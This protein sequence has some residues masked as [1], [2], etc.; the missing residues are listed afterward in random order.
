MAWI[1]IT[2]I[3][4]ILTITIR[5]SICY[6]SIDRIL[7]RLDVLEDKSNKV[8][9]GLQKEIVQIKEDFRVLTEELTE[10]LRRESI[11]RRE[12]IKAI[13]E[14]LQGKDNDTEGSTKQRPTNNLDKRQETIICTAE[15]SEHV[16]KAFQQ[17]K[18]MNFKVRNEL[19]SFKNTHK[20]ILSKLKDNVENSISNTVLKMMSIE[21][22][23]IK[24]LT[25]SMNQA[26]LRL[27]RKVEHVEIM[28]NDAINAL[29]VTVEN[30]KEQ[31]HKSQVIRETNMLK[32][33]EN[34]TSEIHELK[35]NVRSRLPL[36]CKEV[37]VNGV[38][39]II[40]NAN[41]I[42]VYC[43]I[44]T[45]GGGWVVFQRRKDGSEDFNRPW[46]EYKQGFGQLEGEFWL[47]NELLYQ[48]TRYKPR[49]LRIDMEDYNGKKAYA[50]YSSFRI[51]SEELNYKLEVGGYNGN[52]G[53]S[54][55]GLVDK[56]NG[57]HNGQ[58]FSTRDNDNKS[59]CATLYGGGWWFNSCFQANLNGGYKNIRWFSLSRD[60]LKFVEMKFR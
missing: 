53:D 4:C 8:D 10:A 44:E 25:D 11:Y 48:F 52:A 38:Y 41:P 20:D 50:K 21:S 32:L 3:L 51:Y 47:G 54:L 14:L 7:N 18:L 55:N 13:F 45:D 37:I 60:L 43:D 35:I 39:S 9:N 56:G 36:Q 30:Y 22:N 19:E 28:T 1:H 17:E 59:K 23:F 29:N 42:P 49:E 27:L 46:L 57:V 33:I 16:K 40:V 34:M 58:S 15:N 12:D 2:T 5:N 6:L 31:C 24:N 26:E